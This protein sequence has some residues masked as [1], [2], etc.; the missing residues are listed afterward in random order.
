MRC[1]SSKLNNAVITVVRAKTRASVVSGAPRL[2]MLIIFFCSCYARGVPVGSRWSYYL[3]VFA[4]A[5]GNSASRCNG[6]LQNRDVQSDRIYTHIIYV[7]M[8]I[9]H[10]CTCVPI[11]S[12]LEKAQ[13][14]FD[15]FLPSTAKALLSRVPWYY[16]VYTYILHYVRAWTFTDF[17]SAYV[18]I[19][20][21]WGSIWFYLEEF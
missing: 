5:E 4:L 13:T 15:P 6:V 11:Y 1:F 17:S 10:M 7:C 16:I 2:N 21:I 3:C 12:C 9:V 20:C 19:F 8:H 18:F 14:S